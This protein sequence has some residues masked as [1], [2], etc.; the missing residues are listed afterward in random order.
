MKQVAQNE[1]N[2]WNYIK[3]H[4]LMSRVY[5]KDG[6][7]ELKDKHWALATRMRLRVPE[8]EK[9]EGE[10]EEEKKEEEEDKPAE[11]EGE[12]DE[13]KKEPPEPLIP[14]KGLKDYN[15]NGFDS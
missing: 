5:E 6:D 9:K 3:A 4:M 1:E 8:P 14:K 11:G 12:G 15:I 2:Q 7:D 10:E 13:E